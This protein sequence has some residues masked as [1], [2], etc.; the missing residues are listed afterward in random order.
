MNHCFIVLLLFK[1]QKFNRFTRSSL[2]KLF[3]TLLYSPVFFKNRSRVF[4]LNGTPYIIHISSSSYSLNFNYIP[5]FKVKLFRLRSIWPFLQFEFR[6]ALVK[7][8][9]LR[10]KWFFF[11]LNLLIDLASNYWTQLKYRIK[12]LSQTEWK[13][14]FVLNRNS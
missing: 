4:F 11:L 8:S 9:I 1:L 7:K 14:Y 13:H 5:Y 12:I 3:R 2:R 6:V 10:F